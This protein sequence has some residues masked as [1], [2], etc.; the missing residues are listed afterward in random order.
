MAQQEILSDV[1]DSTLATRTD[2]D[3]VERGLHS[4]LE[5]IRIDIA[6][7][8]GEFKLVK[9]MLGIVVGGIIMIALKIYFPV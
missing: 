1:L 2:L 7:L 3:I 4:D 6:E 5:K 9:W 8:K